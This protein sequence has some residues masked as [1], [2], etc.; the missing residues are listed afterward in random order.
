M[1]RTGIAIHV[2]L[3]IAICGALLLFNALQLPTAYAVTAPAKVAYVEG[4]VFIKRQQGE[5]GPEAAEVGT[6]LFRGDTIITKSGR[7]QINLAASGVLRLSA[8]TTI[9]FPVEE[10]P[11]E[12]IGVIKMKEGKTWSN[13]KQLAKDE[14]FEV[15][16]PT[17]VAAIQGT[18]FVV[19]YDPRTG[20]ATIATVSGQVKAI[21][22]DIEKLIKSAKQVSAD[23]KGKLQ[24]IIDI[25]ESKLK[26]FEDIRFKGVKDD[27]DGIM[28]GL[29]SPVDGG[30]VSAREVRVEGTVSDPT[31]REIEIRLSTDG[32]VRRNAQTNKI[33]VKD[34]RFAGKITL[35]DGPNT[36]QINARGKDGRRGSQTIKVTVAAGSAFEIKIDQPQSGMETSKAAVSV[37]GSVSIQ[38]VSELSLNINGTD[39]GK[40]GV[41]DGR[42]QTDVTL[43]E[44][45]NYITVSGKSDRKEARAYV[46]VLYSKPIDNLEISLMSPVEG[47]AA[48]NET[49]GFQGRL[50]D[51]RVEFVTVSLNGGNAQKVAVRDGAFRG[52]TTLK[53][54]ENR[55]VVSA[56]NPEGKTATIERKVVFGATPDGGSSEE[57]ILIFN[58][59]TATAATQNYE[60]KGRV[61]DTNI[62]SVDVILNGNQVSTIQIRNGEY[63][64][65]IRLVDGENKI[66]LIFK[67]RDGKTYRRSISVKYVAGGSGSGV[68]IAPTPPTLIFEQGSN[69]GGFF[70]MGTIVADPPVKEVN[71]YAD[72]KLMG[73]VKVDN[74]QFKAPVQLSDIITQMRVV[75]IWKGDQ[76]YSP[77]AAVYK[78]S[79]APTLLI[80][81]PIANTRYDNSTIR[82]DNPPDIINVQAIVNDELLKSIQYKINLDTPRSATYS[83]INA[84]SFNNPTRLY[85]GRNTIYIIATD[86][87]GNRAQQSVVVDFVPLRNS[88][89][90]GKLTDPSGRA[91]SGALIQLYPTGGQSASNLQATS[92]SDGSY[93]FTNVPLGDYI[94][95]IARDH[96]L[97]YQQHI[98]VTGTTTT[99]NSSLDTTP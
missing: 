91:I 61:T 71:V 44:G 79:N 58:P 12:K 25:D 54:G 11:G 70:L 14:V 31:V 41:K 7:C 20:I 83:G 38:D 75:P 72:S 28:L 56:R 98:K 40:I 26:D 57:G 85:E 59:P 82:V 37:E 63:A 65:T 22:K 94:L 90:R 92:H 73:R 19:T 89:V 24:T 34:G 8:N 47:L 97:P 13:I 5:G 68:E 3:V 52:T 67:T 76:E 95:I 66:D 29:T 80:T 21:T 32:Q 17:L 45:K 42:F 15:R 86:Y 55:L 10:N 69:R 2:T 81:L 6:G 36:L 18:K 78:D 23:K 35:N 27:V 60:I 16:T 50:N 51:P 77:A 39:M 49:L 33:R 4:K 87:F 43:T 93:S 48:E 1:K 53:K 84:V 62:T 99:V 46:E 88:A 96:Y 64:G 9:S 30:E 74:N